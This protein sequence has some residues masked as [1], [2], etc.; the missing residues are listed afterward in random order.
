MTRAIALVSGALM[1]SVVGCEQKASS[2]PPPPKTTQTT[3]AP[4]VPAG[5][6]DATRRVGDAADDMKDSLVRSLESG[7]DKAKTELEALRAKVATATEDKKPEMQAA[8]DRAQVSYDKLKLELADLKTKSG[9][10][11][12]KLST[13]AN[14]TYEDLKARMSDFAAKYK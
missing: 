13:Q 2:P 12:D 3:P 7:L 9:E 8:L 5:V 11:W 1:L 4:T 6:E 10:Q 14:L